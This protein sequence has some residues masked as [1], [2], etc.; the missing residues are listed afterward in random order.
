M[1]RQLLKKRKD[2][3]VVSSKE[4]IA[5]QERYFDLAINDELFIKRGENVFQL[6]CT[7]PNDSMED[8]DDPD[9]DYITKDELLAGIY[10]NLEKFFADKIK[11]AS[12]QPPPK[13]GAFA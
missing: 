7:M 12:P 6:I 2:M 1:R 11:E 10:E 13:E 4:F 5:N 3:T 9:D 8:T